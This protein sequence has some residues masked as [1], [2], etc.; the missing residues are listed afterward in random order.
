MQVPGTEN[1]V[2][3]MAKAIRDPEP[4]NKLEHWENQYEM[5]NPRKRMRRGWY[6]RVEEGA[7]ATGATT[8]TACCL[9]ACP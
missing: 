9:V 1:Q 3:T 7:I 4:S 2:K 6:A 5:A 8:A